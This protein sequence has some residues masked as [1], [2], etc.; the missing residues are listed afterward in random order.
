[1]GLGGSLVVKTAA[2]AAVSASSLL[3]I[4]LCVVVVVIVVVDD[5]VVEARHQ[6]LTGRPP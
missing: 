5:D 2:L 4:P 6:E 1:M 3:G